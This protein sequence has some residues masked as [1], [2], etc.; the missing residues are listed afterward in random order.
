LY[1]RESQSQGDAKETDDISAPAR[2]DKIRAGV[3]LGEGMRVELDDSEV[4]KLELRRYRQKRERYV[5]LQHHRMYRKAKPLI[6]R[7]D[8]L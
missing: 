8:G 4:R 2:R 6:R 1:E 3:I 5:K 7:P